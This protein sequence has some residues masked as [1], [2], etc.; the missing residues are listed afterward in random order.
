MINPGENEDVSVGYAPQTPPSRSPVWAYA[1]CACGAAGVAAYAA[2]WLGLATDR[3][4]CAVMV[5]GPLAM[6]LGAIALIAVRRAPDRYRGKGA[7][8]IA[9]LLGAAGTAGPIVSLWGFAELE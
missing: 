6:A 7:A 1:A 8:L 5:L 3:L 4:F 9:I 2:I